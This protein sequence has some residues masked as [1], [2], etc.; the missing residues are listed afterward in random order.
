M[1][2]DNL[3]K[4]TFYLILLTSFMISTYIT[5]NV[6][7]VKLIKIFDLFII[8]G[9]TLVF[10]IAFIIGDTLTE[11]WGFKIAKKVIIV[12]L[13]CNLF[14]VLFTYIGT[15][16]KSLD[17]MA[18]IDQAYMTI[19]NIVPRILLA[20]IIAF[21]IGELINSWI[22][23]KIKNSSRKVDHQPLWMRIILSSAVGYIF[24]TLVFVVIAFAGTVTM[25]DLLSMAIVQYFIKIIL[26]L[27]IGTPVT[28]II[29]HCLKK[30]INEKQ[31]VKN[32][33]FN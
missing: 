19:F 8:D 2:R 9:G 16:I 6:M 11:I 13:A 29:V 14:F 18:M 23:E 10:P 4:N 1:D 5:A 33:G 21:L 17:S 3:S 20:S 7:A 24:D 15:F 28:Y 25:K 31:E 30:L 26:E 32:E 27:V 22:F 12:S